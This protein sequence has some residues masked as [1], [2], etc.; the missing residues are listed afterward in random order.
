MAEHI[1]RPPM[2]RI[3]ELC[4]RWDRGSPY[5]TSQIGL[6]RNSSA[7]GLFLAGVSSVMGKGTQNDRK[8]FLAT[9]VLT[10]FGLAAALILVFRELM[11]WLGGDVLASIIIVLIATL[12]IVRLFAARRDRTSA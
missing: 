5:A 8:A 3:P 11:Y 7:Q 6:D 1:P 10:L 4:A 2:W 9:R 12:F